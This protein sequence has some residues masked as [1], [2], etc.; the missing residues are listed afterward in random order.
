MGPSG[1]REFIKVLRLLERA[2]LLEL[3]AAVKQALAI[4]AMTSEAVQLLLA[5]RREKP[6][7]LFC[8][9]QRPHLGGVNVPVP[10][11]TVYQCLRTG[12]GA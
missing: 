8:L 10:D 7:V 6:V 9:D 3:Y 12:G 4:G 5:H 2:T 11:L 1:T